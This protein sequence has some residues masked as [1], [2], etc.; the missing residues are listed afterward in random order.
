MTPR[1]HGIID[2]VTAIVLIAAPFV[3]GFV[4][5]NIFALCISVILGVMLLSYSLITDYTY[6]LYGAVSFRIH[7]VFDALAGLALIASPYVLRFDGTVAVYYLVMGLG[8]VTVVVLSGP[9]R[10]SRPIKAAAAGAVGHSLRFLT[11][12]IHSILDYTAVVVLLVAPFLLG[13][14]KT[15][16]AALCIS[17]LL[18]ITLLGYSLITDYAYSLSG[19]ISF[20]IHLAFDALSGLGAIATPFIFGFGGIAKSY[21]II[22]GVGVLIIVALTNPRESGERQSDAVLKTLDFDL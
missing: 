20:K 7:L 17:L 1:V 9:G 6:A 10:N 4:D 22:M 8:L 14:A 16:L 13:F 5:I 11:P 21:C 18:G 19:S 3:L 2:Y 15:S 12:K